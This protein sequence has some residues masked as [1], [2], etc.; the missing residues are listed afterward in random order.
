[1]IP[2]T[3]LPILLAFQQP[4]TALLQIPA[5]WRY[6]RLDF[7]LAFAPELELAGIE[8]LAF[9][10]GMFAPESDSYFSYALALRLAGDVEIDQ[11]FLEH[12]LVTYYR[13][14]CRAVGDERQLE[15][16]LASVAAE[17]RPDGAGFRAHVALFD[18]FVT[19]AALELEL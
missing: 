14:L 7:P 15:L 6:E 19:G 13:G 16:D 8:D 2:L 4:E 9:A 12:F 10:P 17:V 11:G 3:L 1:M 5:G 18:P